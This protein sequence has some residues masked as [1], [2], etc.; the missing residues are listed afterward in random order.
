VFDVKYVL[1]DHKD[2]GNKKIHFNEVGIWVRDPDDFLM[3]YSEIDLNA[4]GVCD[5][6][7]TPALIKRF[8]SIQ[9]LTDIE[10]ECCLSY[11]SF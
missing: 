7:E 6:Y 3:K 8:D 2:V 1:A 11:S 10:K 4:N 5:I 9:E